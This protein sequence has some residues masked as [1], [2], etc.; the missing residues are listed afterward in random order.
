MIA[1][2]I[3]G[4]F[5]SSLCCM[6]AASRNP[7]EFAITTEPQSK[8]HSETQEQPKNT[9]PKPQWKILEKRDNALVLT[10][11]DGHIREIK[12]ETTSSDINAGS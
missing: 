11:T 7:F 3:I 1:H 12:I 8:K 5:L 2:K 9:T 10:N 4:F 6:C